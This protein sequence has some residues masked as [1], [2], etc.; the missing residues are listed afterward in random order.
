MAYHNES[1]GQSPYRSELRILVRKCVDPDQALHYIRGKLAESGPFGPLTL[2]LLYCAVIHSCVIDEGKPTDLICLN[3]ELCL[4]LLACK[5]LGT[6]SIATSS[7][8]CLP[9]SGIW[10][11]A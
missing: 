5:T 9:R 7:S 8:L 2:L 1:R 11:I 6:T 3:N 4:Q 10:K